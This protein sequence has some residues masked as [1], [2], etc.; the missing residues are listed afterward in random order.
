M[1][2]LGISGGVNGRRQR[3]SPLRE[4]LRRSGSGGV[5]G[6]GQCPRCGAK[7]H[8]EAHSGDQ[9]AGAKRLI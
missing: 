5:T 4:P 7:L 1:F 6:D 8:R 9:V 2:L 3:P